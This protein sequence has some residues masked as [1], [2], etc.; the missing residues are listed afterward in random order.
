MKSFFFDFWWRNQSPLGVFMDCKD[1]QAA[2][3]TE[4]EQKQNGI[5]TQCQLNEE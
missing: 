2:T 3:I 5:R 1:L 4:W